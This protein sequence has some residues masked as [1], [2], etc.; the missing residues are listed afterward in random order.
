MLRARPTRYTSVLPE[1]RRL[2]TDLGLVPT[3]EGPGWAVLDAGSGRVRL[4]SV[5]PGSAD[6]GMTAFSVEVRDPEAFAR[7]TVEDGGRASLEDTIGGPRVRLTGPDGFTFYAEPT[8]HGATCADADPAVTVR[9]EWYTPDVAGAA[10]TLAA[11]GARPRT[12]SAGPHDFTAKNGGVL[13]PREAPALRSGG[14]LFEYD[15]DLAALADR[16]AGRGWSPQTSGAEGGAPGRA[17][18]VVRVS[19]PTADGREVTILSAASPIR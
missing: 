17:A 13:A 9:M 8:S 1:L 14:L 6:D 16:L 4:C 19:V 11:I 10:A 18:G 5:Q 2:L 12:G 15:G 7:R 3:E